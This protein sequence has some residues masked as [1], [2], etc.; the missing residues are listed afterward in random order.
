LNLQRLRL[1]R[2]QRHRE[3]RPRHGKSRTTERSSTHRHR[4][5]TR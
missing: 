5:G 1:A 2:I 3:L 4:S